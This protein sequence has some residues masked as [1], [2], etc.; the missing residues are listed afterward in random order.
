MHL[1][2]ALRPVQ[3]CTQRHLKDLRELR[4]NL[5]AVWSRIPTPVGCAAGKLARMTARGLRVGDQGRLWYGS[6]Q[7]GR[8]KSGGVEDHPMR[9]PDP[10]CLCGFCANLLGKA[11]WCVYGRHF[12]SSLCVFATG[13]SDANGRGRTVR[14]PWR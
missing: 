2:V 5:S 14:C 12:Q 3:R 4:W 8:T 6:A 1:L 10:W 11:V 7:A 9:H 13:A